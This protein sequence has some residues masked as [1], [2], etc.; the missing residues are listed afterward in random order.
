LILFSKKEM[1]YFFSLSLFS[2]VM[3][4]PFQTNK[5][6]GKKTINTNWMDSLFMCYYDRLMDLIVSFFF[7]SIPSK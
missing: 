7:K 4:N 5:Q 6:R 1:F 2:L 3:N